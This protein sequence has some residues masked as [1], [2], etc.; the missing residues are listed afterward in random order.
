MAN[1]SGGKILTEYTIIAGINGAG[2][3]TLFN[4]GYLVFPQESIRINSEETIPPYLK[5]I[6]DEYIK[7]FTIYK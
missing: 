3:S 5:N 7:T 6:V 4:A 2:K 1:D